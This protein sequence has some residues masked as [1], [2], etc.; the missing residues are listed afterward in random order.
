MEFKLLIFGSK[1][2]NNL[3]YEV[4]EFLGYSLIF[5]DFSKKSGFVDPL[6]SIILVESSIL[7]EKEC[8]PIIKNFENKPILLLETSDNYKTFNYNEKILLP[9]SFFEL[10]NRITKILTAF[11]FS[12]NSNLKIKEYILDKNKK[13]I[14]KNN[15]SIL[16]TEKE[17]H[18]IELLFNQKKPITKSYILKKIWNY[19]ENANTHTVETHMYRLRKKIYATFND[20]KFILSINKGYII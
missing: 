19:S 16:I 18:L 3:I 13:K 9:I 1:S 4:K 12:V 17:V 7:N 5:Y 11:K 8:L 15:I 10:K 14:T 6:I 2:F 20:D